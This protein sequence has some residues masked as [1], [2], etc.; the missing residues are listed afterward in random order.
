MCIYILKVVLKQVSKNT[1]KN[2]IISEPRNKKQNHHGTD[3]KG[4]ALKVGNRWNLAERKDPRLRNF[5]CG[6]TEEVSAAVDTIFQKLQLTHT[7]KMPSSLS[8]P[9]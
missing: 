4:G 9:L 3:K 8:E 1:E 5:S 2:K 6:Y 7:W